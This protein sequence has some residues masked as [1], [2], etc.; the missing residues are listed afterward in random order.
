MKQKRSY[1]TYTKEF[2]QE[3]VRLMES[4]DRSAV[5]IVMELGIRR[6][7]LYEWKEELSKKGANAFTGPGRPKKKNQSE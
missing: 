1:K 3:A 7:Q 2:R 5:E 6:N 4:T